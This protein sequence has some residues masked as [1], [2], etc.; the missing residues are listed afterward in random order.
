MKT[1]L[2]CIITLSALLS[3]TAFAKP[4]QQEELVNLSINI[5]NIPQRKDNESTAEVEI[6]LLANAAQWQLEQ[7][8]FKVIRLPANNTELSHTFARLP[9]GRYALFAF[10]DANNNQQLDE[11]WLG[12]PEEAF[13]FSGM[14]SLGQD[15]KFIEASFIVSE[16][17]QTKTLTLIEMN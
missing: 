16:K 3:S 12:I 5:K 10:F 1:S 8:P 13:A 6:A 15:L 9:A 4:F 11:D 17:G 2:Y 14:S 7:A